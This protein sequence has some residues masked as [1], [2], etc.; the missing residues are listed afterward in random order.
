MDEIYTCHFPESKMVKDMIETDLEKENHQKKVVDSYLER[1]SVLE[2]KV[3]LDK[4][5]EYTNEEY[6]EDCRRAQ[7]KFCSYGKICLFKYKI[8]K[9]SG[10]RKDSIQWGNLCLQVKIDMFHD[11]KRLIQFAI[12]NEEINPTALPKTIKSVI[13]LTID[14]SI[15]NPVD[16]IKYF[17]TFFSLM[18]KLN[19]SL[20]KKYFDFIITTAIRKNFV[21]IEGLLPFVEF[22]VRKYKEDINAL[23]QESFTNQNLM[24]K[25]FKK[26][27]CCKNSLMNID[28]FHSRLAKSILVEKQIEFSFHLTHV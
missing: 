15:Y 2:N 5:S 26:L 14:L 19:N 7:E 28:F 3:Q 13:A 24:K 21:E 16:R 4:I 10:K 23:E 25:Q 17:E 27:T 1:K 8:L 11:L 12:I 9:N 18:P 6:I 20:W 22:L